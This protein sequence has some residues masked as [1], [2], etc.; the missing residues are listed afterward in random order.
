MS[1]TEYDGIVIGTGQGGK[2]LAANFA[3]AGWKMAIVECGDIGGTCVNVGCTP[4]KTMI[5]SARVAYV[6]SRAAEYGI[7]TGEF[8][9]DLSV[10][11][12]RKRK[13]V[14]SFSSGSEKG[15]ERLESLDLI[16]GVASFS[17]PQTLTV[18]LNAVGVQTITSK[19]VITSKRIFINTGARPTIPNIPGLETVAALTSSTIMELDSV[20]EHLIVIGGGYIGLEFGQM[21]RRFGAEVTIVNR[22]AHLVGREDEDVSETVEEI[23][24]G[25]GMTLELSSSPVKIVKES[26]GEIVLTIAQDGKEKDVRGSHVL[27]A[28]GRTPNSDK[29]NLS[30][31]GIEND[32]RGYIPVDKKLETNVAGVYALGDIN[33]GPAFTHIAYD[34]FRILRANLLENGDKSTSGRLVPYTMFL[35]PQLARV[36]LSEKEARELG[37]DVLVAKI[38][39]TH[40]ARALEMDETRGFMKALV[41][42]KSGEILGAVV[43]GIEGGEV[44]SVLQMA[45]MGK[46]PYSQIR[47]GVFAHPTLAE[48]LNNLFMSLG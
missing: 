11:R 35:D 25:E 41:D 33:G 45:M 42:P 38:P 39:M 17:G 1:A 36:G 2:P 30:A 44:M 14:H 27:L 46:V 32:K 29:L 40:V 16:R 13:I 31:A 26:N 3:R 37:L 19:K 10:V 47:D 8:E 24:H 43:L 23:L 5:A 7:M 12:E 20:P 18:A 21:F 34:D 4:T 28:V 22:G 9:V 15:L 6:A 48:S